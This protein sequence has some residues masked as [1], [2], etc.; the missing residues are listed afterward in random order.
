MEM[1]CDVD[2]LI[3]LFLSYMHFVIFFQNIPIISLLGNWKLQEESSWLTPLPLGENV[4]NSSREILPFGDISPRVERG[5]GDPR[6]F[7]A[8]DLL[9]WAN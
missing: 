8:R 4:P 3:L 6:K 9:P 1:T 5:T 2:V 7:P